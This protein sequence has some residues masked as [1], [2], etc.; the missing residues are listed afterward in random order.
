MAGILGTRKNISISSASY[1][2]GYGLL[3]TSS[4]DHS[5]L[6]KGVILDQTS[7]PDVSLYTVRLPLLYY[8]VGLITR[9]RV[10][11]RRQRRLVEPR[12]ARGQQHTSRKGYIVEMLVDGKV[13]AAVQSVSKHGAREIGACT[14]FVARWSS[15]SIK[16]DRSGCRRTEVLQQLGFICN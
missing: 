5:I 3:A 10:L 6:A 2:A 1:L 16:R 15:R 7:H 8:R 14:V 11:G 12:I 9:C 13:V 4:S